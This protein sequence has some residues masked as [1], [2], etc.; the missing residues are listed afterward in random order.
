MAD[1]V[2]DAAGACAVACVMD[3]EAAT[4]TAAPAMAT[5]IIEPDNLSRMMASFVSVLH[6]CRDGTCGW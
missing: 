3:I 6:V 2:V 1:A 4:P 5:V